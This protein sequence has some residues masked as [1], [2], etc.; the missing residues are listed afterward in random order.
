MGFG[1]SCEGFVLVRGGVGELC[2]FQLEAS[3]S[4]RGGAGSF[5]TITK[6]ATL[7]VNNETRNIDRFMLLVLTLVGTGIHSKV[8]NKYIYILYEE[9]DK[10]IIVEKT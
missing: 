5:P 6:H 1:I 8:Y 4:D 2:N 7:I 10:R 3:Y 9:E